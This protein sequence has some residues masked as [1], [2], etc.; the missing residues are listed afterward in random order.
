MSDGWDVYESERKKVAEAERHANDPTIF[1]AEAIDGAAALLWCDGERDVQAAEASVQMPPVAVLGGLGGDRGADPLRVHAEALERVSKHYLAVSDA[2]LCEELARRLGR[3]KCLIVHRAAA[4]EITDADL[5]AAKPWPIEGLHRIESGTL[6]AL[7][8]RPPPAVMTTG[9]RASDAILRLP[10]DGRLIVVLGFPGAGKTSLTRFLAVHTATEHARRWAIFSP[11]SQPWE[12]FAASCAE[13][14]IGKPFYPR[15][16][17]AWPTMDESE[18]VLAEKWL[19]DHM[20]MLVCD[21]EGQAPTMDWLLERATAAVLRDGA[22][23]LLIDPVNEVAQDGKDDRETVFFG[24]FL[25][26][27]KAFGLRHGCNI[28]I[29]VHP[30]KPMALKAGEKRQAPGPYDAA[31]SSHFA[32]KADLGLTVHAPDP[33]LNRVELHVWKSRSGHWAK[34]GT[35][36][37]L[38]FEPMTGRYTSPTDPDAKDADMP[39]DRWWHD[40]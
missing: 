2:A 22:T 32:N 10:S 40:A 38:D 14:F 11:E 31:S 34:R 27:W 19:A 8:K 30:S 20:T 29:V 24:R 4:E 21:A 7:R 15:R 9:T 5:D 1:N 37:E 28:W 16:N 26:R 6:L 35:V 33:A 39:M 3:H 17:S 12:Q 13:V 23:D 36:A 18:I 25:Q